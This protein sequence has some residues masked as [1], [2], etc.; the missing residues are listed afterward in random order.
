MAAFAALDDLRRVPEGALQVFGGIGTTW[1]HDIHL[2]LRRAATLSALLG[3][4]AG[5]REDIVRH[6][7]AARG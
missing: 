1:E 5:F 3:E 4:R 2:F 6:L 7:E